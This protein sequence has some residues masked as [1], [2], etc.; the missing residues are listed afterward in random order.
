MHREIVN[1][2]V[3]NKFA[4]ASQIPRTTLRVSKSASA[5][6]K[7]VAILNPEHL[8]EQLDESISSPLP[9]HRVRLT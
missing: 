1:F 3:V 7:T 5:I 2:T 4:G 9:D 6:S 8:F